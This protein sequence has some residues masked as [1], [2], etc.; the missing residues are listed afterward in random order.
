MSR[1]IGYRVVIVD[2]PGG[3]DG[4]TTVW[5]WRIVN[6]FGGIV[7]SGCIQYRSEQQARRAARRILG[8]LVWLSGTTI[9][10]NR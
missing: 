9:K 2:K 10:T 4:L 6:G 3:I 8:D 7:G 5:I 1:E